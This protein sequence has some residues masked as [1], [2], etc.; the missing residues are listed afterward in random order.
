MGNLTKAQFTLLGELV[1]YSPLRV[2]P[3]YRPAVALHSKGYAILHTTLSGHGRI[4]APAGGRAHHA[5][6]MKKRA[7]T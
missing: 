1:A 7:G 5:E 6:Q 4:D 3:T 2:S